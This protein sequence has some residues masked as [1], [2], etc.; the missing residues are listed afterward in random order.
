MLATIILTTL[1]GLAAAFAVAKNWKSVVQWFKDFVTGLIGIF[2]TVAKGVAHAAAAFIKVAKEGFADL[3]HKLY[4]EED[5]HY[6][7]EVRVRHLQENE[8]PDWA[9][10]KL[11]QSTTSANNE[12]NITREMESELQMTL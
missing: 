11:Q 1:G 10:K 9:K 5:G 7:E 4:Y 8:L 6:V 2:T 12:S 3:M